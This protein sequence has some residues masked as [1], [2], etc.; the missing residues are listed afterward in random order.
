MTCSSEQVSFLK[1]S[2]LP[3]DPS[4]LQHLSAEQ[5][6]FLHEVEDPLSGIDFPRGSTRW[7]SFDLIPR[8]PWWRTL[9]ATW[10]AAGRAPL[11]G[12]VSQARD[13]PARAWRWYV[14]AGKRAYVNV[15][16]SSPLINK[17]RSVMWK[18]RWS[19]S[20]YIR[21][22]DG[23]WRRFPLASA[24]HVVP[25]PMRETSAP[26]WWGQPRRT[27]REGKRMPAGGS[28]QGQ[29]VVYPSYRRWSIPA[30]ASVD[31][32]LVENKLAALLARDRSD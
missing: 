30:L 24:V 11:R 15:N 7:R 28:K 29:S 19:H 4:I 32:P 21:N 14:I 16:T 12:R 2:I 8:W 3:R 27:G 1:S 6:F 13:I 31:A 26:R 17:G 23:D 25:P 18:T 22:A 20:V 9:G 5:R 10:D